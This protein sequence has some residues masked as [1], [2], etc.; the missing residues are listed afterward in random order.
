MSLL[1]ERTEDTV[2]LTSQTEEMEQ[3][4]V[5]TETTG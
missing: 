1:E 2:S 4:I 3:T 5:S